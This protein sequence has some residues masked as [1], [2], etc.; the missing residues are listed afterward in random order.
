LT[1]APSRVRLQPSAADGYSWTVSAFQEHL[2]KTNLNNKTVGFYQA[3]RDTL[4]YSIEAV[5]PQTLRKF[6]AGSNKEMRA[7]VSYL[8]LFTE[9]QDAKRSRARAHRSFPS[10][11]RQFLEVALSR[12]LFNDWK[13]QT[14]TEQVTEHDADISHP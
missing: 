6:N 1:A 11:Q 2:L 10:P 4:G 12:P 5:S 7:E 13:A 3:I 8:F 14:Y 9:G